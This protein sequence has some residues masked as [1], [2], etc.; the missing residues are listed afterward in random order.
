M[1]PSAANACRT[2]F[3]VRASH[4]YLDGLFLFD[5]LLHLLAEAP[6]RILVLLAEEDQ[7]YKSE[8]SGNPSD[9]AQRDDK[10]H[11]PLHKEASLV[12]PTLTSDGCQMLKTLLLLG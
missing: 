3:L 9:T 7:H 5:E 4:L 11:V 1:A 2:G 10:Y 8:K 6:A 12:S